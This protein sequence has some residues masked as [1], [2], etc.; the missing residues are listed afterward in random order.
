MPLVGQRDINHSHQRFLEE[1]PITLPVVL[2]EH[3]TATI[4]AHW[5]NQPP[6][7]LQLLQELKQKRNFMRH[8]QLSQHEWSNLVR[9]GQSSFTAYNTSLYLYI[10]IAD[11]NVFQP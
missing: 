1:G 8:I 10:Y 4:R 11:Y 7:G 9:C 5:E 3:L 6:T 2:F